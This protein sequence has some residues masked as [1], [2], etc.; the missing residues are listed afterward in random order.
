MTRTFVEI[1]LITAILRSQQGSNKIRS[2][3][4]LLDIF[5]KAK[6]IPEMASGLRYFLNKVVSKTDIA[7]NKADQA[8]VQWACKVAGHALSVLMTHQSP[9]DH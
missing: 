6:E 8:L 9:A 1:L 5:S 7:G 4:I 3:K 2:E